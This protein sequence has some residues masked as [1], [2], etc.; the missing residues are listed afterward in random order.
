MRVSEFPPRHHS[1]QAFF[2]SLAKAADGAFGAA[3]F[4]TD[5]GGPISLPDKFDDL[6]IFGI[7]VA[8]GF[9]DRRQA[10]IWLLARAMSR[11]TKRSKTCW[12]ARS[13]P[14]R[15]RV[16]RSLKGVYKNTRYGKVE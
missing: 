3:E 5:F 13:S 9:F 11:E 8:E 6:A 2:D 10:S 7:E 14:S 1:A 4:F 15:R 16:T 12:A